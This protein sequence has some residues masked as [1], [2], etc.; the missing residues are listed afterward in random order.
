MDDWEINRSLT[1]LDKPGSGTLL[2]KLEKWFPELISQ[3]GETAGGLSCRLRVDRQVEAQGQP[4]MAAPSA[5]EC[6][7]HP[8]QGISH[9]W[10]WLERV[11]AAMLGLD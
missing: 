10:K 3:R 9:D 4:L 2:A 11:A 5:H 6:T 8:K 7:D 1:L